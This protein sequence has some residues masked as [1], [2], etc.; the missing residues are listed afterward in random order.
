MIT[1]CDL[2]SLTAWRCSMNDADP[3]GLYDS[4]AADTPSSGERRWGLLGDCCT[5]MRRLEIVRVLVLACRISLPQPLNKVHLLNHILWTNLYPNARSSLLCYLAVSQANGKV[6]R[7]QEITLQLLVPRLVWKN[8]T[9]NNFNVI[10]CKTKRRFQME[11]WFQQ[12]TCELR[13][14]QQDPK[15]IFPKTI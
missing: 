3:R 10:I 8:K 4:T 7:N 14:G 11:N 12:R 15:E 13:L 1:L 5:W 6:C 9:R 2:H